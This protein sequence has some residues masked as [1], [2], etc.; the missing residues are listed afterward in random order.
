MTGPQVGYLPLT[1]DR[2]GRG[3]H[4]PHQVAEPRQGDHA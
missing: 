2:A 4:E 3:D 1:R